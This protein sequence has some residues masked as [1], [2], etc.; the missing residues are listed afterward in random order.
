MITILNKLP[1]LLLLLLIQTPFYNNKNCSI[2][3]TYSFLI[4]TGLRFI[5]CCWRR[6][7]WRPRSH[8]QLNSRSRHQTINRAESSS[9]RRCRHRKHCLLANTCS[10]SLSLASAHRFQSR[11]RSHPCPALG[12]QFRG[13]LQRSVSRVARHHHHRCGVNVRLSENVSICSQT[14]ESGAASCSVKST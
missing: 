5:S 9:H 6:W 4:I 7:R 3:Y 8:L 11:S 12:H 14:A 10:P 1:E 2:T 13:S